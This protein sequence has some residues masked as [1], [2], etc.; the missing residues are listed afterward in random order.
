MFF[1]WYQAQ[2]SLGGHRDDMFNEIG[3]IDESI[4]RAI[5]DSRVD[6]LYVLLGHPIKNVNNILKEKIGIVA[7]SYVYQMY[8][9]NSKEKRGIG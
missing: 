2:T 4:P 5:Q 9:K 7:L 6:I 3:R 1:F 8:A